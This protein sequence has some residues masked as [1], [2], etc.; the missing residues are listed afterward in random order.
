M[1]PEQFQSSRL[2]IKLN[3]NESEAARH[4]LCNG[5][6]VK[7]AAKIMR[8]DAEKL[9]EIIDIFDGIAD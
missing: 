3:F 2:P 6:D 8:I 1:T 9:Q 4:V 5:L 7:T